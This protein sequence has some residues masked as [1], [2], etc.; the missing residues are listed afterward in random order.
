M[1]T[2]VDNGGVKVPPKAT[3]TDSPE[4]FGDLLAALTKEEAKRLLDYIER[5]K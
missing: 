5:Q 2:S 4:E 3:A 1:R